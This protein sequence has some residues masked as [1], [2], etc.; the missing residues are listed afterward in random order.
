MK[1]S[2]NYWV[3][4]NCA[5]SGNY[6]G[7]WDNDKSFAAGENLAGNRDSE[8][9]A[10]HIGI[11]AIPR[12]DLNS[13]LG[14]SAGETPSVGTSYYIYN[15]DAGKFLVNGN[16]YGTRASLGDSGLLWTMQQ[17]PTTGLY[18]FLNNSNSKDL[19]VTEVDGM[20]VDGAITEGATV[21]KL[22]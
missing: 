16:S 19:F 14:I 2:G 18:T 10:D 4:Q 11:R 3:V 17:N 12:A 5:F 1:S 15:A 8:T 9:S 13:T 6:V 7:L 21:A 20:W 22:L